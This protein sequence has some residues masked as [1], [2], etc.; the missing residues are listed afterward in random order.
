[1]LCNIAN[2]LCQKRLFTGITNT[3]GR[4]ISGGLAGVSCVN[5]LMLNNVSM[6]IAGAAIMLTPFCNDYVTLVIAASV[7]GLCTGKRI[8][9]MSQPE[10]QIRGGSEDKS[11]TF[12]SYFSLKTYVVT[13]H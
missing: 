1:M 12:F 7:F 10:L 3:V 9:F 2:V 5:S 11:K 8:T 4:I 13:P 6:L